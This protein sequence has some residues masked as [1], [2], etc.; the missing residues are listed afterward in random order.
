M[1]NDKL[2]I[3]RLDNH[4]FYMKDNQWTY[5]ESLAAQV[6]E[7]ILPHLFQM[8]HVLGELTNQGLIKTKHIAG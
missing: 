6:S 7:Q 1:M 8:N 4:S 2:L 5:E 3:E